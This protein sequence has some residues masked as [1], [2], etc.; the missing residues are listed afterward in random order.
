MLYI[1]GL[2]VVLAYDFMIYACCVSAHQADEAM[3]EIM[4]GV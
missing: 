1:I 2:I 3:V 4:N